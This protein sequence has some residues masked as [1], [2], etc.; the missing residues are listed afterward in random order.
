[1]ASQT[2]DKAI[3]K[4]KQDIANNKLAPIYLLK[5]EEPYYIDLISNDFEKNIIKDE[6]VKDFNLNVLYGKDTSANNIIAV[7]RQAPFMSDKMIVILKEAQLMDKKQWNLLLPYFQ[8]PSP[9]TV[10]VIGFKKNYDASS[11]GLDIKIKNQIVKSGG[12][13]LES[14]KL[15]YEYQVTK[16][17]EGFLKGKHLTFSPQVP[18]M[19]YEYLGTDLQKIANEVNKLLINLKDRNNITTA[20][21]N[22]YIGISK[23]YNVFELQNAL[24]N[25]NILKANVIVNYFEQN[26]KENPIQMILPVLFSAFSKLLVASQTKPTTLENVAKNLNTSSFIAKSY[27]EALKFYSSDNL[28]KII[29]IFNEYDLKSKGINTPSYTSD[30][31]LLKELVYKILHTR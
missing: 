18:N 8:K 2:I 13:V 24:F 6:S 31:D 30:G 17:I 14:E 20:D 7:C 3:E 25:K 5:G 23:D 10:L 19:L 1:M 9:S 15:K 11:K 12:F 16:W 4:I 28:L 21:V 29:N 27:M 26:T 22:E